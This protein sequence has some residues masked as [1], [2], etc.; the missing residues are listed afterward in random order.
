MKLRVV[1]VAGVLSLPPPALRTS[2]IHLL[3]AAQ[4]ERFDHRRHRVRLGGR[5]AQR[6]R[7]EGTNVR[8]AFCTAKTEPTNIGD[9]RWGT[10][11]PKGSKM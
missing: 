10:S 4:G 3:G 5:S 7:L 8:N 2:G 11:G 6:D 9:H 1:L